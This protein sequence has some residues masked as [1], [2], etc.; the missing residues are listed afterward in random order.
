VPD[1]YLGDIASDLTQRNGKVESFEKQ[2]E[3]TQTIRA[4][5]PLAQMFGYATELRSRTQ[6]RGTFTM[7][8]ARYEPL[9]P[10]GAKRA[11]AGYAPAGVS[12]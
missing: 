8:F 1:Q 5:V 9:P 7:E 4:Q 12:N 2:E 6:G 11:V 3:N 10:E